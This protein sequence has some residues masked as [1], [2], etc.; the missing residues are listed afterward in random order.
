MAHETYEKWLS[1]YGTTSQLSA[2]LPIRRS[3]IQGLPGQLFGLTEFVVL[4]PETLLFVSPQRWVV[5][6]VIHRA[7]CC[8]N[9]VS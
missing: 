9:G 2:E 1:F 8:R 4:V 6:L 7:P 5:Q 3:L